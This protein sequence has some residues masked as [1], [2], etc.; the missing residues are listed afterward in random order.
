MLVLSLNINMG[1][2]C[3]FS[4]IEKGDWCEQYIASAVNAGITYGTGNGKFGRGDSVTRQDI[5]V[6]TVR[7]LE[8]IG[9]NFEK[10]EDY[11]DMDSTSDYAVSAMRKL[12]G[13]KVM[14]GDGQGFLSPADNATRAETAKIIT[15]IMMKG[16]TF[17]AEID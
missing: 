1:G 12:F 11:M 2:K 13:E 8:F 7:A 4:D 9:Y 14:V 16:G 17:D 15:D 10:A 5:A 3:S 6:M